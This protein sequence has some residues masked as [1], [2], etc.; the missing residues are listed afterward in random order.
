MPVRPAIAF[1]PLTVPSLL[2]A[3]LAMGVVVLGSNVLV[4][5]PINDWLTWGAFS[6]PVAFLVSNL[7]NRRFGPQAARKVAWAGFALAVLLSI[8]IATPRIAVASCLAFIAAQLLDITVFDRLRRGRWWRAPMVA[9]T[10]SA[11]LDTTIFWSIAF[12]GSSLPWVSWAAGDLAVKLAIGVFLLVPFRALLW[13]MA[14]RT[15]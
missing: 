14:P 1:A 6:Y 15:A 13:R 3:V 11:T 2:L 12:A 4:Q 5:Y 9:T 7:I 10:C 8:W